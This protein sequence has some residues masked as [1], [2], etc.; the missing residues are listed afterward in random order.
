MEVTLKEK[1]MVVVRK[2]TK[3]GGTKEREEPPSGWI[4]K[5]TI[6]GGAQIRQ[7]RVMKYNGTNDVDITVSTVFTEGVNWAK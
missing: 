1:V 2:E 3:A 6:G 7:S 5:A 4:G